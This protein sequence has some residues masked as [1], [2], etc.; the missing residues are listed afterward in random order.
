[1]DNLERLERV[2]LRAEWIKEDRDV[3]PWLAREVQIIGMK[4]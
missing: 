3:I 4:A 2:D 1:M